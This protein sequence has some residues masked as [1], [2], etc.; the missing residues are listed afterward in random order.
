MRPTKGPSVTGL[1]S[2]TSKLIM[3]TKQ[4]DHVTSMYSM[5]RETQP[6]QQD[7]SSTKSKAPTATTQ[8]DIGSLQ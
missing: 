5:Q 3:N 7:I 4:A 6:S 8:P 1:H 2:N